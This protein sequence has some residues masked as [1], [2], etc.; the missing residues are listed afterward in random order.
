MPVPFPRNAQRLSGACYSFRRFVFGLRI[1]TDKYDF[2]V[3]GGGSGGL[4]SAQRAAEYG[5]K[6]AVIEGGRLGGTC[7]NVGCVPKKV[8][9]TAANLA[10]QLHHAAGYGF[11]IEQTGYDWARFKANRDA[12]IERLNGIYARN[13]GNKSVEHIDGWASF[14]TANQVRVGDRVITAERILIA[15]GGKPTVPDVPGAELGVDSDGFF[16]L[17]QQP[18]KVAVIGSGYISVELGGVLQALG[19]EVHIFARKDSVLRSFDDMLQ[20]AAITALQ[21]DGV[22]MHF[23]FVPAELSRGDDGIAVRSTDDEVFSGF[24]T[25]VWAAGRE[26]NIDG[27]NVEAAGIEVL[28]NKEIP[29]DDYQRTNVKNVYAVGDVTGRVQLTPV[30]IAAGRRLADRIFNNMTDRHLEYHTIPTVIFTHPPTGTVGMTEAEARSEYGDA[31]KVYHSRFTPMFYALSEDKGFAEMKLIVV[32]DEERIVGCH[33]FGDGTD[34]IL[35]G[36]AVAIRMGATKQN[37]DDTIAI[38]PTS[39]EELVTM[40]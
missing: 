6:V 17:E 7:V 37:F 18:R 2:L 19:S 32:G 33:L 38:H 5:A 22:A 26:A 12:Y 27:L 4:A 3:I 31:V 30:A 35:Q 24:D 13:L 25:V 9:W 11:D 39:A 28:P 34:E 21:S 16:E 15:T 36:F 40:R 8:M 29:V 1:M 10:H 14:E 20:K 23:N